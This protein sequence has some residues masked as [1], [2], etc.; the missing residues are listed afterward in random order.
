MFQ[1]KQRPL[2]QTWQNYQRDVSWRQQ[3]EHLGKKFL[4][5]QFTV[6]G[7]VKTKAIDNS[8]VETLSTGGKKTAGKEQSDTCAARKM[9]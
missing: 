2:R 9:R 8:S 3:L 7:F 5:C 1:N 4:R 6:E